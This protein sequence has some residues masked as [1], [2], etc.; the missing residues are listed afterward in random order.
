[1]SKKVKDIYFPNLNYS[2]LYKSYLACKSNKR[3]RK[4][5]ILYSFKFEFYLNNTLNGL[6]LFANV[7]W[8]AKGG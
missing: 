8:G 1:M 6:K 4:D 3:F 5:V 7:V 2:N